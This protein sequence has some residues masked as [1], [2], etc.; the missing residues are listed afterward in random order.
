ML[1]NKAKEHSIM[2]RKP[3][4]GNII[5]AYTMKYISKELKT[6]GYIVEENE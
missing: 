2:I 3:H 5:K 1:F 4:P 6:I